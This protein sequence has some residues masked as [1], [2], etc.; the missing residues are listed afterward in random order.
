MTVHIFP[1]PK[2][3][4]Q[5]RSQFS[6][7]ISVCEFMGE[8]LLKVDSYTQSSYPLKKDWERYNKRYWGRVTRE[9]K[10]ILQKENPEVLILGFAGGTLGHLFQKENQN[11]KITGVDIDPEM[12][13]LGADYFNLN[14][15]NNLE[16]VIEDAIK[17]C[18][19]NSDKKY[20]IIVVD[21]FKGGNFTVDFSEEFLMNL[22]SLNRGKVIINQVFPKKENLREAIDKLK[23]VFD[24]V[25]VIE[26]PPGNVLLVCV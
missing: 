20:D 10:E 21:V 19:S 1:Q 4:Y 14:K 26:V 11:V 12:V 25:A 9:A 23:K 2:I 16:L 15:I 18:E 24:N 22:K 5:T 3:I 6:G 17:W 7:E 13:K 8:R